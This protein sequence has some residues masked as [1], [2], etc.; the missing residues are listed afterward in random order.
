M[1]G[2]RFNSD[3]IFLYDFASNFSPKG[4]LLDVGCGV[5][6]IGLL[7]ARDFPV[8]PTLVEKQAK[9]A[10][11]ARKNMQVNGIEGRLLEGDFLELENRELGAFD[12]IV[13]NPPFYH[14]NVVQS[15]DA[16][17]HACRYSTHLPIDAFF[18]KS[19]SLLKPRGRFIFCYDASQLPQIITA[20]EGAKLRME[21]VRFVHSKAVR[22]AKLV[23]VHARKGSKA[24]TKI[25]P[26]LIAFDGDEQSAEV[27]AI[28]QKARTHTIKCQI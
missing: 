27:K 19:A 1:E 22:P 20:L 4:S 17:M 7:L 2:Y 15:N 10:A 14:E 6:V 16:H 5:G 26:P 25:L 3:S 13:S 11:Y 21:S 12:T 18:K 28:Y 24:Q 23:M 9:M 8:S